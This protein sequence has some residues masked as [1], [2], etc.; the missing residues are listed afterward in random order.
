ND[1]PAK[2]LP[3]VRTLAAKLRDEKS[4][5]LASIVPLFKTD[6]QQQV[7]GLVLQGVAVLEQLQKWADRRSGRR[8]EIDRKRVWRNGDLVVERIADLAGLSVHISPYVSK[9]LA[10]IKR[11]NVD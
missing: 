3:D 2:S 1:E 11:S 6:N 5:M 8:G 10:L 4:H 9:L 7:L